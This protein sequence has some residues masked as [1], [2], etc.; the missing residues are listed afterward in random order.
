MAYY[1]SVSEESPCV[2]PCGTFSRSRR[3]LQVCVMAWHNSMCLLDESPCV[4]VSGSCL[5]VSSIR[6][7]VVVLPCMVLI[8]TV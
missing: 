4:G 2:S 8:V 3:S 7:I 1:F 5:L 6:C